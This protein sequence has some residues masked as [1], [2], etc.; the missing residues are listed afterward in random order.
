M[1]LSTFIVLCN[2]HHHLCTEHFLSYKT[3]TWYLLNPNP[4]SP[5]PPS[6]L[7]LLFYPPSLQ[8]WLLWVPHVSGIRQFLS[9]GDWIASLSVVSLQVYPRGFPLKAQWYVSIHIT[10]LFLHSS[11]HGHYGCSHL[12]A[13]M[14]N[15]AK[16]RGVQ[17]SGSPLSVLL[18]GG[19]FLRC[20]NYPPL[21]HQPIFIL[22]L[23]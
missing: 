6:P 19:M 14:S 22:F 5:F 7:Q 3:T 15:A 10:L 21:S 1:A 20:L 17:T 4:A 2:H 13:L 18:G 11:V 16:N 8:I 9:F 23:N 12:L